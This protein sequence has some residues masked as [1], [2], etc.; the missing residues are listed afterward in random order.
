MSEGNP[1]YIRQNHSRKEHH[2]LSFIETKISVDDLR[3]KTFCFLKDEFLFHEKTKSNLCLSRFRIKTSSID[4]WQIQDHKKYYIQIDYHHLHHHIS[5]K[6]E[7][8]FSCSSDQKMTRNINSCF[9]W[10]EMNEWKGYII[11]TI[12]KDKVSRLSSN[13]NP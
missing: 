12:C 8:F 9:V 13:G 5:Q 1:F 6:K 10:Y 7:L 3:K 2:Q 4:S 11:C